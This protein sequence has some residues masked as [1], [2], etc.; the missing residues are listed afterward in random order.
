MTDTNVLEIA[1]C[2]ITD[3]AKA[4]IARRAAMQAVQNYPGF[5]S[6][7]ALTGHGDRQTVA[8]LVEWKDMDS[9]EKAAALVRTDPAFAPYMKTI[10]SVKLMQHFDATDV[11]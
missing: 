9:A 4:E 10:V 6:W 5:L 2:T 11:I 3:S 7:R 8:D 1:I